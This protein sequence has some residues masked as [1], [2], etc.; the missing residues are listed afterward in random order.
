MKGYNVDNFAV[1][2]SIDSANKKNA[3]CEHLNH[4]KN[5]HYCVIKSKLKTSKEIHILVLSAHWL[6]CG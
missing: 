4:S 1:L 2:I 6:L 5:D 3:I